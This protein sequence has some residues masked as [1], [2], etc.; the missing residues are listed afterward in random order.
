MTN[1]VKA[2]F[3]AAGE[4]VYYEGKFVARFKHMPRSKGSFITFL[5]KNF[6]VE[7]YFA[8]RAADVAPL[9]ILKDKGYIQPH[10]KKWLKDGGYEVSPAGYEQY[11][12]D[13]SAAFKRA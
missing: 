7:E 11:I 13:R 10:I 9:N 3:D 2:N 8:A 1:F 6:T 4:Y 5:V 12:K